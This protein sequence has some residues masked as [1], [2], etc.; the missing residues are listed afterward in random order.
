MIFHH[1]QV[2]DADGAGR[3]LHNSQCRRH[4][5]PLLYR[6]FA[7]L[8]FWWQLPPAGDDKDNDD[9]D[10]DDDDDDD[11]GEIILRRVLIVARLSFSLSFTSFALFVWTDQ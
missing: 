1:G 9:G 5:A 4:L 11:R 3:G 6:A 7:R 2:T 10:T 8:L